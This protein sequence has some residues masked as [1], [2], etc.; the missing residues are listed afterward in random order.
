MLD[1]YKHSSL[2]PTSSYKM[3][4]AIAPNHSYQTEQL[5]TSKFCWGR[6]RARIQMQYA[7]RTFVHLLDRPHIVFQTFI[8]GS[9][10][11]II[12]QSQINHRLY[13]S[14]SV[15]SYHSK[16]KELSS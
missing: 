5:G 16:Q 11:I 2:A 9:I 3:L 7:T 8:L 1:D 14:S 10:L 4:R 6:D 12:V 13:L 15:A